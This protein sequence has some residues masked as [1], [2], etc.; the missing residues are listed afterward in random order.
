M[1]V[2]IDGSIYEG[3]GA[4]FRNSLALSAATQRPVKVFRIRA[5]RS[6]PGLR[7]QHLMVAKALT[8]MTLGKAT[9]LA[10]GS[11]EVIFYPQ[12]VL[13][14]SYVLDI[15]TAGSI[16]LLLQAILP[17]A[18]FASSKVKLKVIG[19]TDV[20]MAPPVDYFHHV[21]LP[22]LRDMGVI[23]H[24][25]LLRRG[26]YPKGGGICEVEVD[27][28]NVLAPILRLERGEITRV[29]GVAHAVRLPKHVV[30][31]IA[32]SAEDALR[33][34]G[35]EGVEIKRDYRPNRGHLGPGAGIVLW[36]IDDL[37]N[38]LGAD[39]LGKRGK[40]SEQVGREAAE[41][42]IKEIQSGCPV[43]RHLGDMLIPYMAMAS[44]RSEIRVSCLTL[45]TLSNIAVAEKIL[46]VS[47]SVSGREGAPATI[48]VEGAAI[49]RS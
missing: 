14:G 44:G 40:P 5:K 13:G 15:G 21:F 8:R 34:H 27:P 42:L 18:V 26:H 31:R 47:F 25:K 4:I 39:A 23:V 28:V 29:S 6:K 12:R 45:H 38:V 1:L 9:G 16:T 22:A 11:Q 20:P 2:E 19:G 46:G 17:A 41:K 7:P 36:A 35:I 10:I 24:L 33:R 30:E 32:S 49:R 43:D 48:A 3:G 37:G